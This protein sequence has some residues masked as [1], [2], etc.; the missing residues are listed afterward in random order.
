[1]PKVVNGFYMQPAM[2][3]CSV[4]SD[5]PFRLRFTRSGVAIG[6]EKLFQ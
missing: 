6:E 2:I 5:V 3:G 1:M 4:E